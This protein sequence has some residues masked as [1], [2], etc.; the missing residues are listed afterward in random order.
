MVQR[1]AGVVD[2]QGEVRLMAWQL[3]NLSFWAWMI[4]SQPILIKIFCEQRE[5]E[6]RE[7]GE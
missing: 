3:L 2:D 7:A 6:R 1:A 4:S 5:R